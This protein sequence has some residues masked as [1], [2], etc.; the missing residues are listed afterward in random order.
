MTSNVGRIRA[1]PEKVRVGSM[2]HFV[3]KAFRNGDCPHY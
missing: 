1:N 3:V 2:L